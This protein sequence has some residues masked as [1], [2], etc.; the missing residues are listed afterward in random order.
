MKASVVEITSV[1]ENPDNPRRHPDAQIEAMKNSLLQFGQIRPIVVDEDNVIIA[2]H[3]LHKAMVELEYKEANAYIVQGL[4]KTQK[5]KLML[6]D[7]KIS[8]MGSDSYDK[9]MELVAGMDDFDIPGYDQDALRDLIADTESA[10]ESY[11]AVDDPEP[12]EGDTQQGDDFFDRGVVGELRKPVEKATDTEPSGVA[13]QT[14]KRIVCP[15]CGG[16]IKIGG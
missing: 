14:E 10:I 9:I 15:H 12:S 11:G 5:N 3:C 16:E 13:V 2:G 7:N 4:S 1:H 6:A 8:Y